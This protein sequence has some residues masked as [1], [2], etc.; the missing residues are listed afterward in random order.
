MLSTFFQHWLLSFQGIPKGAWLLSAVNLINRC[1]SMVL[2]FLSVYLTTHLG[3]HIKDAGYVMTCFGIGAL[4]GMWLGGLATDRFGYYPI[5][6]ASLAANGILL[7]AMVWVTAFWSLCLLVFTLSLVAE[8]FRPANQVAIAY[9]S[10]AETRTRAISLQRMAFNLGFTLAPAL[11]G[12]LAGTM[13]WEWLFWA[14]GITCLL[15]ALA[16]WLLLK[17]GKV[18]K[19]EPTLGTH[20]LPTKGSSPYRDKPF[21]AFTLLTFLGAMVFMQLIWTVPV[22]FKEAYQWTESSIGWAMALN[23]AIVFL[24]EMPFIFFAE[25]KK[26]ML[27]LVRWGILAYALSYLI[28]LLPLSAVGA[29][30]LYML[31]ISVGEILVMPFSSN[32]VYRR[33]GERPNKGQYLA[34]F[35]LSYSVANILAPLLGTQLIAAWGY[36]ALW[37]S[38]IS[39]AIIT[40]YGFYW[41]E[42]RLP[43][44][45]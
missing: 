21:I 33:A 1:G 16:L 35:G 39:L 23:G 7:L 10:T 12:I 29:T 8:M 43:S 20:P 15:S 9:Y 13:G 26:P 28:F 42:K 36:P 38:A 32:L 41:L 17:P 2:V 6:L 18:P 19:A 3:F 14:D 37:T 44:W 25:G 22:F 30:L 34:M 11:G 4:L 27:Y 31:L 40:L 5:Q 45:S 24:I